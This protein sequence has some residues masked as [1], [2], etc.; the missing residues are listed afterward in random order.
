MGGVRMAAR[1]ERMKRGEPGG[2]ETLQAVR[3]PI[4]AMRHRNGCGAKGRREVDA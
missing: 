3:A 4:G 2:G 1:A